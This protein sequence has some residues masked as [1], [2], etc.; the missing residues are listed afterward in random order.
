M[1]K[2]ISN[3]E[4]LTIHFY[5][6]R[7][8]RGCPTNTSVTGSLIKSSF[9]SKS[10][11]HHKSQTIVVWNYIFFFGFRFL[12]WVFWETSLLCIVDELAGGKSLAVGVGV[13]DR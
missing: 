6:S 3:I 13:D 10:S 5:Q 4:E 12:V 7:C 8:S 11:K 2:C 9:S 1:E